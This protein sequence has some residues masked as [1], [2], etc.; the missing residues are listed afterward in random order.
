MSRGRHSKRTFA[1]DGSSSSYRMLALLDAAT[2]PA[3]GLGRGFAAAGCF[4]DCF[5]GAMYSSSLSSSSSPPFRALL[6]PVF[7]LVV[8][9]PC[10]S[11]L[12]EVSRLGRAR[13]LGTTSSSSS[14]SLEEAEDDDDCDECDE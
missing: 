13:F 11:C 12:L 10:P 14:D 3:L 2:A 1:L 4:F 7:L 5:A 9:L 6:L 8:L